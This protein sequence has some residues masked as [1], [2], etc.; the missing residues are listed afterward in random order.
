MEVPRDV[1]IGKNKSIQEV[2]PPDQTSLVKS[3]ELYMSYACDQDCIFCSESSRMGRF[4]RHSLSYAE[5][6]GLIVK[7][8]REGYEHLTFV[9]GEPTIHPFFLKILAA[10]KRL[11]YRILLIT[12]GQKLASGNFASDVLPLL[13]E[14]VFSLHGPNSNIHDS[15]TRR[16]GS[17]NRIMKAIEFVGHSKKSPLTS[18]STVVTQENFKE[19][20]S[21]LHLLGAETAISGH[22]ISN[23]TPN[24][25]QPVEEYAKRAVRICEMRDLAGNLIR[26]AESHEKNI[27]FLG[28]PACIFEGIENARKY[29]A[30]F[31]MI[32]GERSMR[33][34]RLNLED[35]RD[36]GPRRMRFFPP[37]CNPCSLKQK[38][39]HGLLKTYYDC[40]GDSELMPFL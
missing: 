16:R 13:D 27:R 6:I 33:E 38:G 11:R 9:G 20:E 31:H 34:N 14:L 3:F 36:Y 35:S 26:I 19:L 18:T 17:F 15:L 4:R 39:C 24:E 10:A 30:D 25:D 37:V 21:L 1:N 32:N 22:L 7:K 2:N 5:M 12:D 28:F 8:R 29:S 40:F 23:L